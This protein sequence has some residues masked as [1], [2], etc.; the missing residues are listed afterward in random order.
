M[1]YNYLC[2]SQQIYHQSINLLIFYD[3]YKNTNK[4]NDGKGEIPL[5]TIIK[6]ECNNVTKFKNL[7]TNLYEIAQIL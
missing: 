2:K 4:I 3:H 6:Y 5:T 7:Q 1:I